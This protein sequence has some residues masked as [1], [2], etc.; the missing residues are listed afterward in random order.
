MQDSCCLCSALLKRGVP[1]VKRA[2]L[3]SPD[4]SDTENENVARNANGGEDLA[5]NGGPGEER[6]VAQTSGLADEGANSAKG[7]WVAFHSACL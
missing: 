5:T 2:F 4:V 7:Q 6:A 3:P 1:P